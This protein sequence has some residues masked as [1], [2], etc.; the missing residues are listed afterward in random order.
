M[1]KCGWVLSILAFCVVSTAGVTAPGRPP[2]RTINLDMNQRAVNTAQL[3]SALMYLRPDLLAMHSVLAADGLNERTGAIASMARSL[4]MYYVYQPAAASGAGEALLSRH[5]IVR[6][7]RLSGSTTQA[8]PGLK[9]EVKVAGKTLPLVMARPRSAAE[10]RRCVELVSRILKQEPQRPLVVL[11][12]FDPG[13]AMEA[14]KGWGRAGLH[15]A[16]VALRRA[17]PTFPALRPTERLDFVLVTP[18]L[19]PK[20]K[21]IRL[22]EDSRL[23]GASDHLPVEVTFAR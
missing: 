20:L 14:V 9:A 16:A 5:R 10:G 3:Q 13:M 15:D 23:R 7:S 19:R 6:H 21:K 22:I 8:V 12:S 1:R 2:I 11:A 17:E 18:N 4:G